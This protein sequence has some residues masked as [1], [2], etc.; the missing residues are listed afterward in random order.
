MKTKQIL[1]WAWFTYQQSICHGLK[2][3]DQGLYLSNLLL[4]L[5]GVN[6]TW[7]FHLHGLIKSKKQDHVKTKKQL[8]EECKEEEV[9]EGFFAW[10]WW[11]DGHTHT[12]SVPC[13]CQRGQGITQ[14]QDKYGVYWC[15]ANGNRTFKIIRSLQWCKGSGCLWC[16][17]RT[18]GPC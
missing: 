13:V 12:S 4:F 7:S 8:K 16:A 10:S 14:W 6:I 11:Y 18:Q 15:G 5:K 2:T 3:W 9:P 1:W 17:E